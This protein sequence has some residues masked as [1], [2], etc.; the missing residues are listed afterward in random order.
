M[1]IYFQSFCIVA[2]EIFCCKIFFETFCEVRYTEKKLRNNMIIFIL[3]LLIYGTAI[4]LADNLVIKEVVIVGVT[5]TVMYRYLQINLLKSF[6]LSGLFHALL[7][8]VDYLT[9]LLAVT[10]FEGIT[11]L[12]QEYI[13][14]GVLTI[15]LAK[16]VLFFCVIL[17]KQY[18]GRKRAIL[19]S[20]AEWLKF[21]YFPVFTICILVAMINTLGGMENQ[22]AE[23]IFFVIAIGLA[24]MNI[25]VF[26]LINDILEREY[27]IRENE[28]FKVQVSNQM[29]LYQSIS[30]N[31]EKH[32][33]KTHEFKTQILCIDSLLANKNLKEVEEYVRNI[34]GML[35][36]ELDAINTNHTIINAILNTKYAEAID[37]AILFVIKINDLSEIKIRDEDIIVILSNLLNNA[38]EACAKS[39]KKVIKVKFVREKQSVILSVRNTYQG[40]ISCH[41]GEILT[42][43]EE[44]KDEHGIGI[45]NIIDTIKKYNGSYVIKA[46]KGEFYFSSIIPE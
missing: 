27:R 28:L 15:V 6:L 43:K 11:Q 32:R 17:F 18:I 24:G 21:I 29:K 35:S 38:I 34:S 12:G 16:T 19:L 3:I 25:V 14:E 41:N 33:R 40:E 1:L 45:H 39:D 36:K 13:I 20:D 4:F 23:E 9:L 5:A 37:K 10:F 8:L 30:E 46:E 2:L 22:K 44:N 7:L 31:F 42:T 26:Y